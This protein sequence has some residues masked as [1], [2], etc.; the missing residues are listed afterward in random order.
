MAS[1]RTG[2]VSVIAVDNPPH[3]AVKNTAFAPFGAAT[4]NGAIL[5]SN[6]SC[7]DIDEI[8]SATARPSDMIGLHFLSPANTMKLS[9]ISETEQ[10]AKS[11]EPAQP[12]YSISLGNRSS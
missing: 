12:H 3:M 7:L 10:T 11:P 8:E 2:A 5:A 9:E 1:A 4:R 6:P